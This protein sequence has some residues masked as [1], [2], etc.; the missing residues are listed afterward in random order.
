M[1]LTP[2]TPSFSS[3]SWPVY[4]KTSLRALSLEEGRSNLRTRNEH[5]P[6]SIRVHSQPVKSR[7]SKRG[8]NAALQELLEVFQDDTSSDA[9]FATFSKRGLWQEALALHRELTARS[10]EPRRLL[11]LYSHTVSVLS[12]NRQWTHAMDILEQL[13]NDEQEEGWLA[14]ASTLSDEQAIQDAAR[15][16]QAAVTTAVA[17]Q[18]WKQLLRLFEVIRDSAWFPDDST[19]YEG[20]KYLINSGQWAEALYNFEEFRAQHVPSRKLFSEAMKAWGTG[21]HWEQAV[22]LLD[23]MK[24]AKLMPD[25]RSYNAALN[26]CRLA[27]SL[28]ME[29]VIDETDSV[30]EAV[31]IL[32][33]DMKQALLTPDA[34]TYGTAIGSCARAR[35]PDKALEI[36]G[37]M[38]KAAADGAD[39]SLNPN[40]IIYSSLITAMTASET[41]EWWPK[42]LSLLEEMRA[43]DLTPSRICLNGVI[44]VLERAR[45]WQRALLVLDDMDKPDEMSFCLA[46]SACSRGQNWQWALEI[47]QRPANKASE[48]FVF[49]ALANSF[50]K[51]G[52]WQRSLKIITDMR[53]AGIL[54]G[55]VAYNSAMIACDVT[56]E[57]QI[58]LSLLQEML[59]IEVAPDSTSYGTL[60]SACDRAKQYLLVMELLSDMEGRRL[61]PALVT[62]SLAVGACQKHLSQ[63]VTAA[64][65][66]VNQPDAKR[67]PKKVWT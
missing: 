29:G 59:T 38:T 7:S 65:D 39:K 50:A 51:G 35:V 48:D 26:A 61:Q 60:I 47:F 1:F 57:W 16:Y 19:A 22:D 27:S 18:K 3:S 30:V 8:R 66:A 5:P 17:S 56:F 9:V 46:I 10:Q 31:C 45:Q 12:Q 42:A 62:Y 21:S 6:R 32:L 28:P 41:S 13:F 25:L 67:K 58:A 15:F 33:A 14:S 43:K 44:S 24:A 2:A 63:L 23:E 49:Y 36:F 20:L 64:K 55:V 53:E 40:V 37:E 34:M 52:Q 4:R 54:P 11:G